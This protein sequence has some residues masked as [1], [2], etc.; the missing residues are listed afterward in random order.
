[1]E[2]LN[3]TDAMVMK[4]FL[5]AALLVYALV[6]VKVVLEIANDYRKTTLQK[7]LFILIIFATPVLGLLYF[8]LF[9]RKK[10]F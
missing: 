5:L 2:L 6:L 3:A 1:M 9:D 10:D 4:L 8:F 7:I